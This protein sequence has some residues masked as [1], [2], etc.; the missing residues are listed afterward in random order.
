MALVAAQKQTN[1]NQD[2]VAQ[3]RLVHAGRILVLAL[4]ACSTACWF[5][6]Q[7]ARSLDDSDEEDLRTSSHSSAGLN[8]IFLLLGA[9][10]FQDDDGLSSKKD[11]SQALCICMLYI[12]S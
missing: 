6:L 2:K 8:I 9:I 12:P 5:T 1:Q 7:D 11:G 10:H 3:L 4:H